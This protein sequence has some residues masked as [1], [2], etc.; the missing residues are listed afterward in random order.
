MLKVVIA[1]DGP[2][3]DRTY[4]T[5]KKELGTVFIEL[6]KPNLCL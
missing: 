4:D 2:Y 6:E 1:T 5:I 3:G